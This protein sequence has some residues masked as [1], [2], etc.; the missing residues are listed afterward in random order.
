[1]LS[2]MFS[3]QAKAGASFFAT[4]RFIPEITSEFGHGLILEIRAN[5]DD[6]KRYLDRKISQLQPFVQRNPALQEEIKAKITKAADGMFLLAQLYVDSL[7]DKTTPKAVRLALSV[8][9]TESEPSRDG[10][11]STALDHAYRQV[12]ERIEGQEPG[13]RD[14][15]KKALSWIT[16]AKRRL[17]TVKLRHTLAVE[18]NESQLDPE[19]LVEAEDIVSISA[20]LV[21][22][23]KE[24]D[25]IRLVHYT[26]QEYFRLT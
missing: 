1:M 5:D 15:A 25:I 13:L 10:K 3:L 11:I 22:V 17:T 16:C 26:T 4:S 6:V 12:M 24:S 19:N 7:A 14:D 18:A 2:E 20:G 21:T 23:D 9:P 8:F